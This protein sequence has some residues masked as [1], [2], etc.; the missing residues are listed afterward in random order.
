MKVL[1]LEILKDYEELNQAFE[2]WSANSKLQMS[3]L[4]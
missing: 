2:K 3:F 1:C 4:H